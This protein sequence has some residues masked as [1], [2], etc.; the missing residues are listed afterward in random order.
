MCSDDA[1][2][3]LASLDGGSKSSKRLG[4]AGPGSSAK[5]AARSKKKSGKA[6]KLKDDSSGGAGAR[7][8][9]LDALDP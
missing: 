6:R 2:L 7:M 3:G 8:R 1:S 5:C 4:A 9:H